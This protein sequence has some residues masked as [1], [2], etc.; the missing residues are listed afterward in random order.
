MSR[1]EGWNQNMKPR[2]YV[3]QNADKHWTVRDREN[4]HQI[5]ETHATR[6]SARDAIAR[7]NGRAEESTGRDDR[8][9]ETRRP[10]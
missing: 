4:G 10:L 3:E 7:L 2:Y 6:R 8:S 1:R 5:T 9:Q